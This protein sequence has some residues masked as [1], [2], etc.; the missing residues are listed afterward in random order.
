MKKKT[1]PF[2]FSVLICFCFSAIV[3]LNSFIN[4]N[5]FKQEDDLKAAFQ[6]NNKKT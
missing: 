4:A 3:P 1:L 6:S 2:Y 5:E